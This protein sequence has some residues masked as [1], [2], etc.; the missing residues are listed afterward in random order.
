MRWGWEEVLVFSWLWQRPNRATGD[1]TLCTGLVSHTYKFTSIHHFF[2][3]SLQPLPQQ[4]YMGIPGNNRLEPMCTCRVPMSLM[5]WKG[6][7]SQFPTSKHHSRALL[8]DARLGNE[9]TKSK[10][11]DNINLGHEGLPRRESMWKIEQMSTI[12]GSRE[13]NEPEQRQDVRLELTEYHGASNRNHWIQK[14]SRSTSTQDVFIYIEI[15]VFEL[16][17][18]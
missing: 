3:L 7:A 6:Y 18:F 17:Y 16:W 9:Y 8:P 2:L 12:W 1:V 14:R 15:L 4:V 10:Y 13:N 5:S 11:M